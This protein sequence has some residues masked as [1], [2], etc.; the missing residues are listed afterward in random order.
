MDASSSGHYLHPAESTGLQEGA[1]SRKMQLLVQDPNM[2]PFDL[3]DAGTTIE[4]VKRR[5]MEE[6]DK[7]YDIPV[8]KSLGIT[9]VSPLPS[10]QVPSTSQLTST[11]SLPPAD[12]ALPAG[13]QDPCTDSDTSSETA[14]LSNINNTAAPVAPKPTVDRAHTLVYYHLPHESV[15]YRI[16][17]P[18]NP[19]TL[20]QFKAAI[21][22]KGKYRYYF[23]QYSVELK[24]P[25]FFEVSKDDE[26]LPR[27]EGIVVAKV[28]PCPL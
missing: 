6:T 26:V 14:T 10:A 18:H 17:I 27:Y 25:V 21:T 20:Q 28:D 22:R 2:P 23:R 9:A 1:G 19:L 15:P 4:E 12:V 11:S 24:R 8:F 7:S 3:P 16:K 13:G 5:L